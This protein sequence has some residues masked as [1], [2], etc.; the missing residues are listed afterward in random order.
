[1]SIRI[2]VDEHPMQRV[3]RETGLSVKGAIERAYAGLP[4]RLRPASPH[5]TVHVHVDGKSVELGYEHILSKAE[6]DA[7]IHVEIEARRAE[8]TPRDDRCRGKQA[9]LLFG[10]G[11]TRLAW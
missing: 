1:M 4:V 2:R 9:P 8:R 7:S 11:A 6:S 10:S 5:D 3:E